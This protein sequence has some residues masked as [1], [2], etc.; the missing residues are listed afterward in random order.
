VA[1]EEILGVVQRVLREGPFSMRQLAEDAGLSYGVLRAWAMG[2]RTP[3]SENLSRIADGFERR[4]E[5]LHAIITELR[6]AA[7]EH[8]KD[9]QRG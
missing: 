7:G 2:R 5:R 3:T 9:E 6:Q 1:R 8:S 4:T